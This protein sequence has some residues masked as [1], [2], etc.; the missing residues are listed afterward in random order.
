MLLAAVDPQD[1][2]RAIVPLKANL[3]APAMP[4]EYRIDD[5]GRWWWGPMAKDLTADY[6]LRG[7]QRERAPARRDAEDFLREMLANDPQPTK[8]VARAAEA[9]GIRSSALDRARKR[10]AVV[11]AR[12]G[13]LADAGEWML[14]LPKNPKSLSCVSEDVRDLSTGDEE[15]LPL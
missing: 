1:G 12:V 11:A 10:L 4:I 15:A 7:T 2:R 6:L 5:E 3:S 14:S 8:A 9:A 13:G